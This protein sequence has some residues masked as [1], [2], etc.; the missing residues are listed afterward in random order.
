MDD[1]RISIDMAAGLDAPVLTI[2]VGGVEPNTLGV[3]ESLKLVADRVAD[4]APYAAERGVSL[5]LEPLHPVYGGDR[6]CLVTARDA[7][8]LCSAI[9]HD[10]VGLAIDVYHVWWDTSLAAEL[11]RAGQARILG[12]HLCDW[13]ASTRDVLLDRGKMGDGLADLKAIRAA[14]E[15]TGYAGPC[16]VE[17]FS[18]GDWWKRDPGEVLD[19]CVE[20]FRT[21]C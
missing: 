9:G 17:I 4:A 6:S 3:S 16:E 7:V 1:F 13:L 12:Y 5:A 11:R 10:N 14:V 8:G 18:A 2:V 20:R 19:R 15:A 21:V